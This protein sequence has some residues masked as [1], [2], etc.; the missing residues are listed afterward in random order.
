M[1]R[2]CYG[3]YL[4]DISMFIVDIKYLDN[5][6]FCRNFCCFAVVVTPVSMQLSG[7]MV[8]IAVA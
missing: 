3:I 6:N 5:I 7:L 2:E 8:G 4:L 1:L